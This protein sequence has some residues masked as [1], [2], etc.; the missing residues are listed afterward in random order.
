M[1]FLT[2]FSL[3]SRI[4]M[5]QIMWKKEDQKYC[6]CAF[7]FIGLA[8]WGLQY[9]LKY[10]MVTWLCWQDI[11]VAIG[12]ALV[13]VWL[14]VALSGR[15]MDTSDAKSSWRPGKSFRFYQIHSRGFCSNTSTAMWRFTCWA[16]GTV[17]I[18]W[19]TLEAWPFMEL[20]LCM[21]EY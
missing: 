9:A 12:L 6:L 4:P 10:F 15:F 17:C 7:P 3:Y 16:F 20:A 11:Y 8:I 21:P 13:L 5:P 14:P 2:A 18:I 1:S 19:L